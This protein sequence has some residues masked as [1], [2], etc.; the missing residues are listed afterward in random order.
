[1]SRPSEE[2]FDLLVVVADLDQQEAMKGLLSRSH[3]LKTSPFK[4]KVDKLNSRD[5]GT[6][7]QGAEYLRTRQNTFSYAILLFDRHGAGAD[8]S[9][10]QFENELDQRLASYG[11]G[12]RTCCIVIDPEIEAWVWGE[13][14]R[15]D[16]A[17]GWTPLEN[18]RGWLRD[19]QWLRPGEFKPSRPKEAL[20][21]ALK[22]AGKKPTAPLFRKLAEN[23][24]F[25]NCQDRAF[26]RLLTTLRT[27]F[28]ASTP[29]EPS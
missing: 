15:V 14:P 27:W 26:V 1:M 18:L 25:R 11:L 5:A 8:D 10:E 22:V 16:E 20:H 13:S 3:S 9:A 4:F 29:E 28:P 12:E 21:A 2:E 17:I 24:S 6:R 7:T 23:V 19:N